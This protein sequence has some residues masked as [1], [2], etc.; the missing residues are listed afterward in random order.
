[1]TRRFTA[2]LGG[3]I[4]LH[5]TVAGGFALPMSGID[6]RGAAVTVDSGVLESAAAEPRLDTTGASAE[7][8][9]CQDAANC[10]M[11]ELPG[12][13]PPASPCPSGISAPAGLISWVMAAPRTLQ[14]AVEALRVPHTR[15]SPP[16][17]PPPRS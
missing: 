14:P 9:S 1:M 5:L 2:L 15:L 16:E 8:R 13:C 17:L 6:A 4:A 7:A 10:H 3:I 11:P 12:G